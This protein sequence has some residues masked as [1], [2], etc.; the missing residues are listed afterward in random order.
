[1]SDWESIAMDAEEDENRILDKNMQ[2]EDY[3]MVK[4]P[5]IIYLIKF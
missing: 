1:M 3:D 5:I 4:M 2:V